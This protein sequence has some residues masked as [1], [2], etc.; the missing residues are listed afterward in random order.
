MIFLCI[1]LSILVC[2]PAVN[3]MFAKI[4]KTYWVVIVVKNFRSNI[5]L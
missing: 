3:T 5:F 2:I 1:I 4:I